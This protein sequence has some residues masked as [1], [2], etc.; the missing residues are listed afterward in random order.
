[1]ASA[2]TVAVT[3]ATPVQV[4]VTLSPTAGG[5]VTSTPAGISCPGT[6]SAPFAPNSTVT[7]TAASN[8]GYLFNSW[9]GCGNESGVNPCQLNVGS[10]NRALT[11][12]FM[13]TQVSD[14]FNRAFTTSLGNPWQQTHTAGTWDAFWGALTLDGANT[15]MMR[16]LDGYSTPHGTLALW[17]DGGTYNPQYSQLVAVSTSTNQPA[18]G[19]GVGVRLSGTASSARG[20]AALAFGDGRI[21]IVKLNGTN[22]Q[23]SAGQQLLEVAISFS[24]GNVLRIEATGSTIIARR[25]LSEGNALAGVWADTWTVNDSTIPSGLPGIVGA[26]RGGSNG[27]GADVRWDNWKGGA[28][29]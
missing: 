4:S 1:M 14:N 28:R 2:K 16:P 11:A 3:F 19:T 21:R 10:T 6:C 7:L 20:Y 17:N 23:T 22:M 13:S 15:V 24:A 5:S 25:A 26:W 18:W 12:T 9:S 27:M 29:Q 8:S